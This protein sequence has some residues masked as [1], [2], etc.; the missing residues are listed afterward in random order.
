MIKNLQVA[1]VALMASTAAYADGGNTTNQSFDKAKSLLLKKVYRSDS[2]RQTVYCGAQ[3]N[4]RKKV[5][6]Q[7]GYENSVWRNR[8]KKVEIEHIVAA[9]NFGRSFPE[10]RDG[11]V[12]CVDKHGK[13][14]KGRK[15]ATKA[16]AQYRYMQADLYNLWPAQGSINAAHSN[17]RW[18]MLTNID[19]RFGSCNFKYD[20]KANLAEPTDRAKG[21]VARSAMYMASVYPKHYRLSKQQDRLFASWD[22][23]YPVTKWECERAERIATLQGNVNP[24]L[25]ARCK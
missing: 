1:Q 10:W 12:L 16:S 18:A 19:T 2:D 17:Y 21:I 20:S 25:A 9:E 24:I 14:Y 5:T 23:Q 3:F 22:K 15:C 4:N 11:S 6:L 7:P 13:K 8:A